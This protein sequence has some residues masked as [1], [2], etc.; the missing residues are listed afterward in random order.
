MPDT[1]NLSKQQ[2]QVS[3]GNQN[4][5]PLLEL[6]LLW[7]SAKRLGIPSPPTFLLTIPEA[8][9]ALKV[10]ERHV[11]EML[12]DKSL[13]SVKLGRRCLIDPR[14]LLSLINFCKS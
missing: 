1:T 14:D 3:A 13:R 8:A 4:A 12:A 6:V 5:D 2:S 7:L 10:S 11:A 9:A